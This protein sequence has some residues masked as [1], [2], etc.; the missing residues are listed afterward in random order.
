MFITFI[1]DVAFI[2]GHVRGKL[3]RGRFTHF[4]G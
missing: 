1:V 2:P 3:A 4:Y